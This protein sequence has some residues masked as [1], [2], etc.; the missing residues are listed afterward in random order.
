M[1]AWLGNHAKLKIAA[2]VVGGYFTALGFVT[3]PLFIMEESVQVAQGGTWA[4][5][6]AKDWEGMNTGCDMVT[7]IA[8]DLDWVNTRFGWLN[9]FSYWAY[10]HYAKG[11]KYYAVACHKQADAKG[12][13]Y[14]RGN[15]GRTT[16]YPAHNEDGSGNAQ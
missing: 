13:P 11:S 3:F 4:A 2:A 14:K 10:G 7:V 5:K 12:E 9:P 6:A 16:E 15:P 1:A 8:D